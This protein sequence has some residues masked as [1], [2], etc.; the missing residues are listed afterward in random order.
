MR[1]TGGGSGAGVLVGSTGAAVGVSVGAG[2]GAASGARSHAAIESKD[3]A[4]AASGI[5][6]LF[7]FMMTPSRYEPRLK[8]LPGLAAVAGLDQCKHGVKVI[9]ERFRAGHRPSDR[10]STRLN[11]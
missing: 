4:A 11:S 8:G 6:K 5:R 2:V 7:L 9:A 10:K 1:C 3:S